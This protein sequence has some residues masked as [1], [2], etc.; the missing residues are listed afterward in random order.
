M[1]IRPATTSDVPAIAAMI[2]E[3]AQ[4][5]HL[6]HELRATEAQLREALFGEHPAAE[7]LIAERDA[8]S[9]PPP[10]HTVFARWASNA[11]SSRT[12]LSQ[13]R[14]RNRSSG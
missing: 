8:E 9:L 5:E 4:Y 12:G 7:A 13:R 1:L 11:G 2:R 3:L 10:P 14:P 6:E